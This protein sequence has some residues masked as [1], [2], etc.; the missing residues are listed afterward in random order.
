MATFTA[1]LFS[2]FLSRLF[3]QPSVYNAQSVSRSAA[4]PSTNGVAGATTMTAAHLVQYSFLLLL[5]AI[6]VVLYYITIYQNA[7]NFPYE[8]DLNSALS[9]IA[10]YHFGGLSFWEKLKLIFSQ[11]NEHRIVFDRLVFLLDYALVGQLTFTH[12][13]FIGNLAPLLIGYLFMKVVFRGVPLNQKLLFLLPVAYSLFSFQYWELSTWSMAALQNLYVIP[14]ALFSLYSLC[15]PGRNAFMLAA[16]AA[17]LATFTSGNGMFTFIAGVGILLLLQAYRKLGVWLLIT[18][19]TIGCYFIGYIRPPYHPDIVDSLFNHTGRAIS[20][21][22][23]LIGSMLGPGRAKIALLFGGASVLITLGLLGY[24]WFRKKLIIHLPLVGWIAFLYLTCLSLMASRSGMG[25]EQ[26]FTPRYGIIAVMLFATQAVLAIEA[27][28]HRYARLAVLGLFLLVSV[29]FYVSGNNQGNRRRLADRTLQMKYN[30]AIYNEKPDMV[31]LH[32]GNPETANVIFRDVTQKGIYQVPDLTFS[33]L[34]SP[35]LPCDAT[36]LIASHT[37]TY[38]VKPYVSGDFLVFYRAWAQ[39]NKDTP[40][41]LSVQ[42][43]ARSATSCFAFAT[44][45]HTWDDVVDHTLGGHYTQPG[46][47]CVLNKKDLKPGHYDLWLCLTSGTSS[48]YE[49][50]HLTLDV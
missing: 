38:E 15:K 24:L 10:D 43:I 40:R 35:L 37:I 48:T 25:V 16:G 21:F 9:F 41:D 44:Y 23:T 11:Y 30:S 20:Y 29:F 4:S 18:A 22:F 46:F 45:K 31:S 47:S 2:L 28:T 49:P 39:L 19:I 3:P 7:Y 1:N 34:K 17:V 36:K 50:I 33:D 32:W 14:F 27:V 12:L 5:L 13:I 6:P 26:A 8:D 42:L